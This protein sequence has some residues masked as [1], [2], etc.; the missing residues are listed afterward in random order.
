MSMTL[1]E[2]KAR[3][4]DLRA[5]VLVVEKAVRQL[6]GDVMS[7][8]SP[9]PEQGDCRAEAPANAMLAVRHLE[10]ARMRLG[11]VI[12]WAEGGV[13]IYDRPVK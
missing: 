4:N 5:E 6:K 12:Q 2:L 10:D 7:N 13:S 1:E 8:D 9:V 11:K 3:C